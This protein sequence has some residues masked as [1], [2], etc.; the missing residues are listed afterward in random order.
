MNRLHNLP[1]FQWYVATGV[2]CYIL[3]IC[4]VYIPIGILIAL[5]VI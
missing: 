2:I 4:V 5:G 1:E 3:A